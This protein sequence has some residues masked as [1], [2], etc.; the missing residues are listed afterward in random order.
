[1]PDISSYLRSEFSDI[2]L[3]E[4]L[5]QPLSILLGVNLD[6]IN[7]LKD[8]GINTIFDLGASRLFT[9]AQIATE[10]DQ[11]STLSGRMGLAPS[12]WLKPA[13]TFESLSDIPT[14]PLEYL[15]GLT[16]TQ[17][18]TL[19]IALDVTTIRDFAFWPPRR[20][21]YK[22]VNDSVGTSID[23]DEDQS[24]TLRPRFGEYPTERVYYSTLTMLQMDENS[25][26]SQLQKPISLLPTV[27][28][29]TG[30]GKPAV[31]VLLTFSQ[32]WYAKGVTLG[33]MLHSLAL[34]PGEATRI[35]VIDW[36][37]RTTAT[38]TE[39]ISETEELDNATR[40]SRAIS[41]V[42]NA[43]A[44]ELQQGG[45]MSSGWANSSSKSGAVA[46][47]TG[48]LTSLFVSGSAS[49][50]YQDA[51]TNFSSESS[52]WSVGSRSISADMSQKVNDRTE[53]Y[54]NSVRNRRATAVREV[55]QSE[56]ESVSTRIVANYNH[57]HALTVQYYEVVQVYQVAAQLHKAERCI[58]VPFELLDFASPN[59]IDIVERFRGALLRGAL[60]TKARDL[61]IDDVTMVSI[62]ANSQ[63]RVP[64]PSIFGNQDV[65]VATE[66]MANIGDSKPNTTSKEPSSGKDKNAAATP[67][68]NMIWH[69]NA[70]VKMAHVY[71]R[72]TLRSSSDIPDLTADTELLGISF[73]GLNLAT[74]LLNRPG[75]TTTDNTF[76]ISTNAHVD[77]P[78]G[79][80]LS[81][82][83][84]ISVA[85]AADDTLHAGHMTL[86]C[87]YHGRP[88]NT[89][90]IL[91]QLDPG[92]AVQQVLSLQTNEADRQKKL[93]TH[94][95]ANRTHYSQV[96][97][98]SLDSATLV[99]LLSPFEWNGKA[100]VD[101]VEPTPL[102]VAGNYL[103][104]RAP[105][106]SDERSGVNNNGNNQTWGT[107]LDERGIDFKISNSRLV[108][109]PTGGVFA[110]AVLGRSNS[111]E[112]LDI[113]RF[114]NWQDSPIPL[115]PPEISP[116]GTGSR[117]T[118]EN[119]TPGNLSS[120]VL[121]IVNPTSLP[122][123]AGLAA[124]LG[125]V[126]TSN[127]FRDMS[128]LQGTQALSEAALKETL[129]TATQAGQLASTNMQTEAQKA[130][131]MGQIAADLAKAAMGIPPTG[132]TKG[133]SAEGARI[134]N[135]RDMDERGV[136]GASG[137]T[138]G[139]SGA[140]PGSSGG[141]SGGG[142]SNS[143]SSGGDD[144]GNGFSREGAYAD[145]GAFGY[146]PD[147]MKQSVAA[148]V[149]NNSDIELDIEKANMPWIR[150]FH[151]DEN[152]K[153]GEITLIATVMPAVPAGATFVWSTFG[154]DALEIVS[155]NA[156]QTVVRGGKPGVTTLACEILDANK[157][158]LQQN[159]TWIGVPQF[160]SIFENTDGYPT[161]NVGIT[162][163]HLFDSVLREFHLTS[164]RSLI[165]QRAK[166]VSDFILQKTNVRMIWDLPPFNEKL[167]S[168]YLD[169]GFAS[170]QFVRMSIAGYA[171]MIFGREVE[172]TTLATTL[173][174]KLTGSVD[175]SIAIFP[176]GMERFKEKGNNFVPFL[177]LI[178]SITTAENASA[179]DPNNTVLQ[180]DLN[181]LYEL[182]GEMLGRVIGSVMAHEV[183]H[184]I[185]G[186]KVL[187]KG[188][189]KAPDVD[190]LSPA[191]ENISNATG[192]ALLD[193]NAFPAIGSYSIFDVNSVARLQPKNQDLV[194]VSF[195]VPPQSPFEF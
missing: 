31:G 129:A 155:P 194:A 143:D 34:A 7:A 12:D 83:D 73:S 76:T 71:G 97:F 58:F 165:L 112:K 115:Q 153:S 72:S 121:N 65:T 37:R 89:P 1:M 131:A 177:K 149:N 174:S 100:L 57:M 103:V 158:R 189:T 181:R 106:E 28:Q 164:K 150:T 35:A 64:R 118:S 36:S 135:G 111:A 138:S 157:Q 161:N 21:A 173:P 101:Q 125:A 27:D 179:L 184:A 90:Q 88:V 51:S 188:H 82:I 180:N 77:L 33:H 145:R 63:A 20:V 186:Q 86:H 80:L 47:S 113:T 169:G 114:W 54:A 66:M 183:F 45:S 68:T 2:E 134:N 70:I 104:F 137:A 15:N 109:I 132:S 171:G 40:H 60:T 119:L 3:H 85:R 154:S 94:L 133:I 46:A 156:Q 41:E 26:R 130:V 43:V 170:G 175:A 56:H 53:Q 5:H 166:N 151:P 190:V 17:A 81:E 102:T 191:I 50:T 8:I 55:S 139:G 95:Q 187:E 9:H 141:S 75:V 195:P 167:P 91:I 163:P 24:E 23:P 127:L 16:D 193:K 92:T 192:I 146:S 14:L 162:S 42:Q 136:S 25:E 128:G 4:A 98:R 144:F 110:E 74:M 48:L 126:S 105:I 178:P 38:A 61:I 93:L 185:L 176:G 87:S 117:G 52:S 124:S 168:Q 29:P 152:D 44:N 182:G 32:S 10:V 78:P 62:K 142:Y 22:L 123:P 159:T 11:P 172:N 59:A 13:A 99:M 18:T 84:A 30:F 147:A 79:I 122:D 120:P 116:V 96:A 160:V 69:Q 6:A 148:V 67:Y 19:K 39:A 108:P 49:G 140:I 107:V